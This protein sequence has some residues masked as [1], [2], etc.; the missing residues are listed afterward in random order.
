MSTYQTT[1]LF[2]P[3]K[4]ATNEWARRKLL[5]QDTLRQ[6]YGNLQNVAGGK[7]FRP[8][9]P[10]LR[11]KE[12]VSAAGG[13]ERAGAATVRPMYRHRFRLVPVPSY[14]KGVYALRAESGRMYNP[15]IF[16][17]PKDRAAR[18]RERA[19]PPSLRDERVH[20]RFAAVCECDESGGWDYVRVDR[21]FTS[22]EDAAHAAMELVEVFTARD[23]EETAEFDR[24]RDASEIYHELGERLGILR[25]GLLVILPPIRTSLLLMDAEARRVAADAISCILEERRRLMGERAELLAGYGA[26]DGWL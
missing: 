5:L 18:R 16:A 12:D 11:R 22:E 8:L 14:M 9:H 21:L 1:G 26:H 3:L 20:L 2:H 13:V 19:F 10:S 17:M 23:D 25:R 4:V 6:K 7:P 15:A 24:A